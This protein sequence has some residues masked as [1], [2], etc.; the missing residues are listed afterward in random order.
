[1]DHRERALAA[2]ER[3]PVDRLAWWDSLWS[4]TR[5]RYVAEGHLEEGENPVEHFDMSC[6]SAGWL[7]SVVDLDFEPEV[8]HEDD[9]S[10]T[11]L[12]G[13]GA[14]LRYWKGRSGT[15]EHVGFTVTDRAGWEEHAKP[16]L[17]ALDPR[18]YDAEGYRS[19]REWAASGKR[20]LSWS[21]LAPFEQMHPLCGHEHMLMGMALDP[22]WIKDM[23]DT[24]ADL[25]LRHLDRLFAEGGGP[26]DYLMYYEDMGFKDHPFMS[27]DMYER[28]VQ[29]AHARLFAHAH[30]LGCKVMVHSCGYVEPLV[31][32]LIDAG[33]DCLQAME[34]KAGM[35]LA[36][37]AKRFGDRISFCG[38]IDI[39][40]IASNDRQA[41]VEETRRRVGPVLECGSGYI[42]HSDH[43]IPPDVDYATLRFFFEECSALFGD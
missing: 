33:M 3:R 21:G 29:P 38:G 12:D 24:Y 34:V 42:L 10:I 20:A 22:D 30:A 37:L 5:R 43:S 35:D 13:N 1:M 6:R 16:H 23:A 8:I 17:L 36:S 27:P 4:E 11:R 39:R 9:E 28:L 14:R 19:A 26:P 15:P 31:P 2:L 32:G 7:D 40:V 25:T 18:R 41:I